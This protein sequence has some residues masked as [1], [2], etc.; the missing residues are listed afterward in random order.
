M[1]KHLD[2]SLYAFSSLGPGTGQKNALVPSAEGEL[3]A[4]LVD[5]GLARDV[6]D[7]LGEVS[8]TRRDSRA[9]KQR[10]RR[11]RGRHCRAGQH[12]RAGQ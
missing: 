12:R 9:K 10:R 6:N 3:A 7:A 4:G 1:V 2:I 8:L 11:G 5:E